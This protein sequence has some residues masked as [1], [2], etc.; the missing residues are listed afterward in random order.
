MTQQKKHLDTV[1]AVDEFVKSDSDFD[2]VQMAGANLW[3][4][5]YAKVGTSVALIVDGAR[6]VYAHADYRYPEDSASLVV[7]TETVVITHSTADVRA[8]T[9]PTVQVIPRSSLTGFTIS[10]SEGLT[11]GD[12]GSL[13]WPGRVELSL[14][15]P[16]LGSPLQIG[17]NGWGAEA[18]AVSSPVLDLVHGLTVD[19]AA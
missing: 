19:L 4:G 7:F 14:T 8:K 11:K 3:S 6:V 12:T 9:A 15:Y 18:G 2:H 17:A 13:T 5:W 16:A 10:S 1:R